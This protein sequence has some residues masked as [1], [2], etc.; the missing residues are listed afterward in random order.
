MIEVSRGGTDDDGFREDEQEEDEDEEEDATHAESLLSS[1]PTTS[2]MGDAS[3]ATA[4]AMTV[5]MMFRARGIRIDHD[6]E[7]AAL[8]VR[9]GRPALRGL[10]REDEN[11]PSCHIF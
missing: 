11:Q 4:R 8:C 10:S 2:A 3:V 7:T 1:A 6:V 9:V 5:K